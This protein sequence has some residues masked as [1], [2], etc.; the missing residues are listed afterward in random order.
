MNDGDCLGRMVIAGREWHKQ[1][2]IRPPH[3]AHWTV[4][5]S[6]LEGVHR[7]AGIMG[8]LWAHVLFGWGDSSKQTEGSTVSD[9]ELKRSLKSQHGTIFETNIRF[10]YH[11]GQ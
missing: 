7:I 5:H 8:L 6:Q 2:K 1:G 10:G 3:D 4:T 11:I 9:L